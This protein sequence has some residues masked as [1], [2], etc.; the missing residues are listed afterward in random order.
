MEALPAA[1]DWPLGTVAFCQIQSKGN[2]TLIRLRGEEEL[3]ERRD[4]ISLYSHFVDNG[5]LKKQIVQRQGAVIRVQ[6]L[7]RSRR[8]S[9]I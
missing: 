5:F 9:R 7:I 1:M 2:K 3:E 6:H 8:R 4:G